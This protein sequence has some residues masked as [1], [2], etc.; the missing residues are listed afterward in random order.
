MGKIAKTSHFYQ[1]Y[2]TVKMS[3]LDAIIAKEYAIRQEAMTK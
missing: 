3:G 2:K 1:D